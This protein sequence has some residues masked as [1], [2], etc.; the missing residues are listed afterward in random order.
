MMRGVVVTV[1]TTPTLLATGAS[2]GAQVSEVHLQNLSGV[3]I[4]VGG[5]DVATTTGL[6]VVSSDSIF[7]P[8][9]I[10]AGAD[11][12]GIVAAATQPIRVLQSL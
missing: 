10:K 1:S 3:D 11:L 5:P 12:Y 9:A 2:V 7:G 4:Y 8:I 6:K